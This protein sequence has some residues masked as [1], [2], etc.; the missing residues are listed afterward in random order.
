MTVLGT[1]TQTITIGGSGGTAVVLNKIEIA[2]KY[3][4]Y[5]AKFEA[6]KKRELFI[7]NSKNRNIDTHE[8]ILVETVYAVVDVSEEVI[9]KFTFRFTHTSGDTASSIIAMLEALSFFMD[10]DVAQNLIDFQS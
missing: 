8:V 2:K 4:N 6:L 10:A 5:Y 7:N 9:R 1:E 3:S